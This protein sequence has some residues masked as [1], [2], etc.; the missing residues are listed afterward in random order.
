M[1][2][3]GLRIIKTP[4]KPIKIA[5]HVLTDTFSFKI[6]A[7]NATTITGANDP[8]LWALARDKYLNDKTKHPD[9]ITDNKLL[10]IWD[11]IFLD[12]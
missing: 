6:I 3:V 11:L 4:T 5:I 10:N 9:S 2:D 12:L 1:D 7:D 8:I